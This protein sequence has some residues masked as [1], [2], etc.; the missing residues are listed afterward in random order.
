MA[1]GT[2]VLVTPVGSIPDIIKDGN[3][4]FIMQNNSSKN[5]ADNVLRALENPDLEKIAENA[6]KLVVQQ[7]TYE[8]AIKRYEKILL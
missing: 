8:A 7:F 6:K 4:G 2:P 1:C 3:N 5:I